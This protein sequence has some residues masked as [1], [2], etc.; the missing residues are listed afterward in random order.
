MK[1]SQ[2]IQIL[3]NALIK[4][5]DVDVTVSETLWVYNT[6]KS[7]RYIKNPYVDSDEPV[8]EIVDYES[9]VDDWYDVL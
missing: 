4:Y 1:T 6:V 5:G 3:N 8:I 2:L 7:V 9:E